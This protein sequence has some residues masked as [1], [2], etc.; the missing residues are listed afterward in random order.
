M[1][2]SEILKQWLEHLHALGKSRLTL[3]AYGRALEHFERWN[4]ATYGDAFDPAAVIGRDIQDWKAYQQTVEK[5]APAT[6]NQRLVAMSGFFAWAVGQ[7]LLRHDPTTAA[8]ALRLP[9]VP[10]RS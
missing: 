5:A 7:G 3:A 4:K 9:H 1:T 2:D 10:G 6:I 8:S